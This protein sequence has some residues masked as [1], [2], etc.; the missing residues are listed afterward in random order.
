MINVPSSEFIKSTQGLP[1]P[2]RYVIIKLAPLYDGDMDIY[3]INFR[4]P[5]ICKRSFTGEC[6]DLVWA[7][8]FEFK[9]NPNEHFEWCYVNFQE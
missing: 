7:N 9:F 2:N 5:C 6:K 1:A 8:C 4:T 3:H